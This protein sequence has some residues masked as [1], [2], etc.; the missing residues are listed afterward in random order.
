[1]GTIRSGKHQ[2]WEPAGVGTSRSGNQQEWEAS[3]VETTR[4]GN[5]QMWEPSGMGAIRNENHQEGEPSVVVTIRRWS[6]GVI[7]SGNQILIFQL[8]WDVMAVRP[9]YHCKKKY[10]AVWNQNLYIGE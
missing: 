7:K 6:F 3:G 1:V 5:H 10:A 2:E 4:R 8:N 9:V